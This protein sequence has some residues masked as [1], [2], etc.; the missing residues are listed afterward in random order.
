M[1]LGGV[2]VAPSAL[3]ENRS[4]RGWQSREAGMAASTSAEAAR[5]AWIDRGTVA[6]LHGIG[7]W[8]R[9][10]GARIV[11]CASM[12]GRRELRVQAPEHFVAHGTLGVQDLQQTPRHVGV[13]LP[14]RRHKPRTEMADRFRAVVRCGFG[15]EELAERTW[16]REQAPQTARPQRAADRKRGAVSG[17]PSWTRVRD[18]IVRAEWTLVRGAARLHAQYGGPKGR[19]HLTG[20]SPQR[21]G[22]KGGLQ[23]QAG[24]PSLVGHPG[25][26]PGANGLRIHCSTT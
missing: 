8:Q 1:R 16:V 3:H 19:V 15:G 21:E 18:A 20:S 14:K 23:R 5:F 17:G 2:R 12:P 6:G 24:L 22:L 4:D 10:S 11:Q 25:L 13:D 7:V 9:V 26:E